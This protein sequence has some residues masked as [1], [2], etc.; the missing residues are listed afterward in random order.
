MRRTLPFLLVIAL[1][2]TGL[3]PAW[4]QSTARLSLF[5]LQTDAFPTIT[6]GLDVFDPAGVFITGLTSD[7]ITLLE[8]DQ[9]RP[10]TSLQEL[11][12]GTEFALALDPGPFFAYQDSNAVT[13]FDKVNK[14]LQDWC[15]SHSDALGDDL[16]L[17]PTGGIASTHL[18]TTAEFSSALAAYKPDLQKSNSDPAT[19]SSALDVV[20]GA[21]P[22]AGMKP[23]VLYI[24]SVPSADDIPALNNLAQRAV[25]QHVRVQVWVVS[26]QAFFSTSGA[27][28]LKDLAIRTGG[29]AVFFSGEE[30]LPSPETYLAALRHSYLLT[31]ASGILA[32]GQH[33]LTVQVTLNG[34]AIPAAPLSFPLDVQP[35][36][37]MLVSPPA[38]IVRSAPDVHTTALA[39]FVPTSQPI[40]IIVEF[41]D[42]RTRPLVRTALYVDG[43]KVAENT[44]EPF[45]Q[46]NWD[47][48]GMETSGQHLLSV[49]AVDSFGL[50]KTSIGVPVTVTI[51]R[52][53]A[54][55]VPFLSRNSQW[56]ALAAIFIAGLGLGVTLT[57]SLRRKHRPARASGRAQADP[58]T[59]AVQ[60]SEKRS[61]LRLPWGRSSRQAEAYLVRLR[62]DGQAI[63]SP[64]IPLTTSEMIFGSDPLRA[65]RILDDPSVSPLHARLR[66]SHGEYILSDEGS[67][68][69]TWVNYEQL[70]APRSLKHGDVLQIGRF[71]YRFMLR[72]PPER[73]APTVTPLPK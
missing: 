12:P 5:D 11:Q 43:Q 50:S 42:G 47:V 35:P 71:S 57:L 24:T 49:E 4:A 48:S 30:A 8:D 37:P 19:L 53:Q 44:T 51:V 33:S 15:S 63:T 72:V 73:P 34:E 10:L 39:S 16:S 23:I 67:T 60:D 14:A 9:P 22:R 54:G 38:Q 41:P 45:D 56:L 31:Y 62:E 70:N 25:D 46:F 6:V 18:V 21:T 66:F 3:L 17:V 28:A 65:S 55:L 2:F 7:A 64:S 68:A 1:L 26:S 40:K 36:N 61:G 29:E 59:Q 27:T 58:L 52:P 13:R 32:S 20:S 69:G